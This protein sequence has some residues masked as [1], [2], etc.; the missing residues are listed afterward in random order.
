MNQPTELPRIRIRDPLTNPV[1]GRIHWKPSKSLWLVSNYLIAVIGGAL[2][3]SV[4]AIAVFALTTAITLCVGHSLGMHRL[5]IHRS[6]KCPRWLEYLFVHCGVLVGM[7]GPYGMVW[8]HD[9]RDWAQR[10]RNCHSYLR[11]GESFWKDGWWQLHCELELEHPPEFVPEQRI[12]QDRIY[13]F[14]EQTWM[15]QQLP[16]AAILFMLGGLPWVIWGICAR[17]S[18][19]VTGHWLIGYFA[20][21]E[22]EMDHVVTG[23]AVQGRNVRWS[24]Y[25]TMGES[26]HNNHHAFPGSAVLGLYDNQPDPGWRVLV[27]LKNLGLVWDIVLPIDLP[28]RSNLVRLSNRAKTGQGGKVPEPCPILTAFQ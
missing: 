15:F 8:M 24:A 11:H 2:T 13:R 21:N 6:Y 22:G 19:S 18:V 25:L 16:L 17:V 4:Q 14:M 26:W 3:V 27:A 10:Q 20:H 1:D 28:E 7:A 9:L 5:L 12:A 23:A